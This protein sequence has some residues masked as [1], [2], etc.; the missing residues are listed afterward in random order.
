LTSPNKFKIV[1][2]VLG[3]ANANKTFFR[4]QNGES[5]AMGKNTSQELFPENF[6]PNI[7]SK[8]L[9]EKDTQIVD[10]AF[11]SSHSLFLSKNGVVFGN[12][13]CNN[14]QLGSQ[15]TNVIIME[16]I[17]FFQ[18]KIL[19][20]SANHNTS[21][22]LTVQKE[23]FGVGENHAGQLG[24]GHNET[25]KIPKKIPIKEPVVNMYCG[26]HL[27]GS[28]IFLTES[29]VV[30]GCGYN[31]E[32]FLGTHDELNRNIPTQMVIPENRKIKAFC[33]ENIKSTWYILKLLLIAHS[34]SK[35]CIWT[36]V[37]IEIIKEIC[38]F[39]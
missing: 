9:I 10:A 35:I 31:N 24:F 39:I 27:N 11:G 3:A 22:F 36:R 20:I 2:F 26:S 38:K 4:T 5:F 32:G 6:I 21:L 29:G 16:K 8:L 28:L 18:C 12:G 19:K 30:Y 1:Y 37:P 33:N 14:Y 23:V 34:Q 17:N 25:V 7:P 13:K 15:K